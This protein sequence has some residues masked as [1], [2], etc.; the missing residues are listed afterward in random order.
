MKNRVWKLKFQLSFLQE[1]INDWESTE[2][3]MKIC[4]ITA[5]IEHNSWLILIQTIIVRVN[6]LHTQTHIATH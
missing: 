4:H 3:S 1:T 2:T 5:K 6:S